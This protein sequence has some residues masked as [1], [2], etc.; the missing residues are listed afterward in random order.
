MKE[1]QKSYKAEQFL[2]CM[3]NSFISLFA[4]FVIKIIGVSRINCHINKKMY[5]NTHF[6]KKPEKFNF[7]DINKGYLFLCFSLFFVKIR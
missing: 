6:E 1:K 3:C 2:L 5:G 7:L 4:L